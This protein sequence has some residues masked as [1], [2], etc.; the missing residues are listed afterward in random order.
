MLIKDFGLMLLDLLCRW[1]VLKG[2]SV[3]K[4]GELWKLIFLG[5]SMVGFIL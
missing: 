2:I 4:D 5:L 3:R 1:F